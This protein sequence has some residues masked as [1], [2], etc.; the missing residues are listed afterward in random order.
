M[1]TIVDVTILGNRYKLKSSD[2][3]AGQLEEL[4]ARLDARM[5]ETAS[6]LKRVNPLNVSI[7]TALQL[8]EELA[9][10]HGEA[11]AAYAKLQKQYND[12]LARL[13][14]Q[15]AAELA[16]CKKDAAELEK[17]HLEEMAKLRQDMDRLEKKH[18][19]E[20]AQCRAEQAAQGRKHADELAKLTDG[21]KESLSQLT[22][23]HEALVAELRQAHS[24]EMAKV[25]QEHSQ[26]MAKVQQEQSRRY[27][28][29][30]A[31]HASLK[32]DYDELMEL[33]E[34]T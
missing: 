29:L 24:Q 28:A 9:K 14:R 11:R 10:S 12:E 17:N 22:R 25:Q 30:Q 18:A 34:E 13:G 31:E 20:L 6:H 32:K 16:Q 4:A 5:Q 27:E 8:A 21:Q 1:A 26:E 3:E 2:N 23:Q 33:L 19:D 7:L 15:H